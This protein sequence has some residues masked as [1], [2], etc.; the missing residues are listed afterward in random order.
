MPVRVRNLSNSQVAMYLKCPRQWAYR[1][2]DGIKTPPSG[3]MKLSGVGHSVIEYAYKEKT[4][5]LKDLPMN[6]ITDLY[7]TTWREELEREEVQWNVDEDGVKEEPTKVRDAGIVSVQK[8]RERIMPKVMP[9]SEAHVEEWFDIPLRIKE[10][11]DRHLRLTGSPDPNCVDCK[12]LT[13]VYHLQGKI[14]VT[15]INQI[16]RDNKIVAPQRVPDPVT[17]AKDIQL[18]TYALA[19]RIKTKSAEHGLALDCA[20]RPTKLKGA[21]AVSIPTTRTRDFLLEHLNTIGHVA[22]GILHEAFPRRTDG[23]W[24]S[25]KFCGYWSRCVGRNLTVIDLG[26]RVKEELEAS[27][28]MLKEEKETADGG[29]QRRDAGVPAV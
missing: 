9:L 15:D 12:A 7:A 19:K 28:E 5:T 16:I 1:Y 22:R 26:E 17:I 27:L 10:P 21:R 2:V 25:E 14:D 13:I 20:V 24:C 6:D 18:S 8:F 23:W 29:E 4:K 3:A 11:C